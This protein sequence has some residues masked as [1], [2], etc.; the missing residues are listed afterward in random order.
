SCANT[1]APAVTV[2][3]LESSVEGPSPSV[4]RRSG[5]TI[6]PRIK[7]ARS[8]PMWAE[9]STL[10]RAPYN[11]LYPMKIKRLFSFWFT[12]FRSIGTF[13]KNK[14]ETNAPATPKIAPDAPALVR[15]GFHATLAR[16]AATPVKT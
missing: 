9:L 1:G 5:G 8:P 10:P 14:Y 13:F 3:A 11:R 4:R 2:V 16:L 7:P 12:K 15:Q 6:A